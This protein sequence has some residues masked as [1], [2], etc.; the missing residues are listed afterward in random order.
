MTASS[1]S[2][3]VLIV[4]DERHIAEVL[5][6]YLH[7]DGFRTERVGDG[8]TALALSRAAQPYLVLLNVML[9]KLDGFEVLKQLCLATPVIMVTAR[10]EDI[11]RIDRLVSFRMGADDY[12]VKPF[13]PP[14]VVERVEAVLRRLRPQAANDARLYAGTLE[15]DPHGMQ[16]RIGEKALELTLTEY[17]L[18]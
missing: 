18:L 5:E 14:E 12:G 1:P 7:R 10:V 17:G 13:N 8:E 11:D 3:F 2:P 4:E 9:P 16:A 6:A 15:V